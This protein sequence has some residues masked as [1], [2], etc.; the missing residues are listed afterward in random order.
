MVKTLIVDDEYNAR[1]F[2]EKLLHR[3]FPN[4]F[5]VVGKA[6]SVDEA[7]I[8]IKNNTPQLVFLDIQMPNKDGFELFKEIDTTNFE[9]IFTTAHSDFAINAIKRSA[10]DYLLKPLNYVDL[11][12]AIKRFEGKSKVSQQQHQIKLLLENITVGGGDHKKIAL[13]TESGFEFVKVNSIV[14]CKAESNYCNVV[15]LNGSRIIISKTL[16]HVEE[17]L[18]SPSFFRI[19]KSYLVNLNFIVRFDKAADM[20]VELSNGEKLPVAYR[21]KELFIQAITSRNNE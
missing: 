12:S 2:L 3:Y 5:I 18:T 14:Y 17:L 19:H 10:L 7:V 21:K 1:E 20:Y 4:K 15:C 16:K 6:E 8:A 9:V 13:P 11:A